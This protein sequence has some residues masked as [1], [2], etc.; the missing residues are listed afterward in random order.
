MVS[1]LTDESSPRRTKLGLRGLT[2][3]KSQGNTQ[4]SWQKN[5]RLT[6]KN[7]FLREFEVFLNWSDD[8]F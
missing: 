2:T 6:L 7:N 5:L 3:K 4:S 1:F 8:V